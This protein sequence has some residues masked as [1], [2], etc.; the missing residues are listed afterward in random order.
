MKKMLKKIIVTVISIIVLI[1]AIVLISG[2]FWANTDHGK[3]SYRIATIL[4]F[5]N[6]FTDTKPNHYL[7]MRSESRSRTKLLQGAPVKVASVKD[8]NIPGPG[9]KL[10]I[11]VYR[12]DEKNILPVIVFFHGGGWVIGNLDNNDNICRFLALKVP[13]AVVSV[14]YRLAPENKFPA[15][16]NDCYSAL[17]WVSKNA[18][19]LKVD[20]SRIA[21]GG[22]S[23]G[24]NLAAVVSLL[25]RDRGGPKISFQVLIYPSVNISDIDNNSY[26]AFAEGYGLTRDHIIFF[27]DHYL[28]DNKDWKNPY[29]SPLLAD[30]L[31][32]LPPAVII[33]AGFDVLREE[34]E[35]YA[36]RLKEAGVSVRLKRFSEMVH[37]FTGMDWIVPEAE[38]SLDISAAAFRETFTK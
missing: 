14:G 31:S 16:V 21:V 28:A 10:P 24:G 18:A 2:L 6:A 37:G 27:R 30:N 29:V 19:G 17:K 11:R 13:C 8:M 1:I 36:G 35:A 20:P 9:G 34:G 26:R 7:K 33:T 4:K 23:A 32:G 38:E 3:L 12:P 15:A 5:R 22:C 25:A